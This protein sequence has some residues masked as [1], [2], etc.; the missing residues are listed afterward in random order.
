MVLADLTFD[1]VTPKSIGFIWIHPGWMCGPSLKK[2]G[3]GV[4]ELLIGNEKVTDGQIGRPTCTKPYA[5]STSN[6]GIIKIDFFT[7]PD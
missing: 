1:P 5:L 3:Q 4:L 2:V 7:F 6:G